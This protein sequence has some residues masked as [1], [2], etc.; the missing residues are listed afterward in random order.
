MKTFI[1]WLFFIPIASWTFLMFLNYDDVPFL[2]LLIPFLIT[3]AMID[4]KWDDDPKE[5]KMWE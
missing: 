1:F 3:L 2:W 4:A 5:G